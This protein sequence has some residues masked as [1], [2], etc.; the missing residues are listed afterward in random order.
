MTPE[1]QYERLMQLVDELV[2]AHGWHLP[3]KERSAR[4][5]LDAELRSLLQLPSHQPQHE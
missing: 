4:L 1:E 3:D 5:A 2:D